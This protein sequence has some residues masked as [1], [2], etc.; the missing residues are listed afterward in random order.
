MIIISNA[1]EFFMEGK[2]QAVR[3]RTEFLKN[4]LGIDVIK[5]C[6]TWNCKGGIRQRAYRIL[7]VDE[8][9]KELWDS[10]KQISSSM[11]AVWSGQ[12]M[13]SRVH[14]FWKVK[15]WDE[16]GL[17]GAWSDP[18]EFEMGLLSET[19]W[20]ARWIT[21]NYRVDKKKRYPADCFSGNLRQ[22]MSERPDFISVPADCM[23]PE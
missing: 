4:P 10:G 20:K 18:A 3:L 16:S 1:K 12:K 14:V 15:L 9:G 6:L 23:K 19:D 11:R 13:V 22:K 5:P 21:G 7:A 8:A 2:M 17:E